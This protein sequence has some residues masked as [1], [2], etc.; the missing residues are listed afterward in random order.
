M[1]CKDSKSLAM[2]TETLEYFL[3]LSKNL[4]FTRTAEAV[5]I[6]QPALSRA[7]SHAEDE[8]G[9]RVFERTRNSVSITPQG[10][11]FLNNLSISMDTYKHGIA[12]AKG[13]GKEKKSHITVG[14]VPD[15][16]NKDIID[17][18]LFLNKERP[19]LEIHLE[20]IYYY[21]MKDA[22]KKKKVDVIVATKFLPEYSKDEKFFVLG[23]SPLCLI[24]SVENELSFRQSVQPSDIAD[25]VII[26]LRHDDSLSRTW[27]F[28]QRFFD[29]FKVLPMV[30]KR[31][32]N[33]SSL[34]THILCNRGVSICPEIT[35]SSCTEEEKKQVIKIN[36]ENCPEAERHVTWRKE[37]NSKEV[38]A[39]VN[40]MKMTKSRYY[41]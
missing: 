2:N 15:A 7:I 10:R 37:E 23:T 38:M 26:D 11:V 40:A 6:S 5:N 33:K 18:V 29:Y 20:E 13:K 28:C 32:S 19:D 41:K 25:M 30:Q 9:F 4:S 22:L 17:T 34:I 3:I 31:V 39:F 24:A 27:S 16:M 14:Y 8:L 1:K 21:G 35:Y 12:V 36:I